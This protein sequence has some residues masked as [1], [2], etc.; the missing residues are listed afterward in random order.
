PAQQR[1]GERTP[2]ELQTEWQTVWGLSARQRD[3]RIAGEV[4][5]N[6]ESAAVSQEGRRCTGGG[7]GG[8]ASLRPFRVGSRS[9]G[10]RRRTGEDME[11]LKRLLKCPSQLGTTQARLCVGGAGD[12][13]SV[14]KKLAE[15][16]AVVRGAGRERGL[17]C[18]SCLCR[19]KNSPTARGLVHRGHADGYDLR[20]EALQFA[21]G[22]SHRG[23]H[24]CCDTARR[25]CL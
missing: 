7:G 1:F 10:H 11:A 21:Y 13:T 6:D 23:D 14:F 3:S 19:A 9:F 12:R 22:L 25:V 2:D 18:H 17:V 4:V 15:E 20:A 16:L 8:N 5:G 24:V